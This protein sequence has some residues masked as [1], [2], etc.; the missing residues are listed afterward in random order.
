MEQVMQDGPWLIRNN[1]L[2]LK[3]WSTNTELKK[4]ELKKIPVWV[5]MHDVPLAAYTEDGLSLIASKV[6]TPKILDNETTKMSLDS[7]GRSGYARA[8]VELDADKELEDSVTVA[9]PNVEEGGYL[10]SN[11]RV[12]YEWKPP[13]CKT[14]NVFGHGTDECPTKVKEPADKRDHVKES[15]DDQGF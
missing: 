6:G 5:K 9:I 10:K 13:H 15:V 1:P 12:E 7:W 4:E 11:I 2:F 3:Q 8:I 14:C